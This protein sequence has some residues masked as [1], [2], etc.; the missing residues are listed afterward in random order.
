MD[1]KLVRIRRALATSAPPAFKCRHRPPSRTGIGLACV[2]DGA[3]YTSGF[4]GMKP[5]PVSQHQVGHC[6]NFS[7]AWTNKVSSAANSYGAY[8]GHRLYLLLWKT[9]CGQQTTP[10]TAQT[11][12]NN[13]HFGGRVGVPTFTVA[14]GDNQFKSFMI[15]ESSAAY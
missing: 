12:A 10:G 13:G 6:Y 2:W 9:T 3:N 14:E 11:I 1:A 8:N 7:T 5:I 15:Y 4:V